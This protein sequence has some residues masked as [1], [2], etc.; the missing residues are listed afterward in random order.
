MATFVQRG[1]LIALGLLIGLTLLEGCLR[2]AALVLPQRLQRAEVGSTSWSPD[3]LVILCVGDSHTYGVGVAPEEAYPAQVERVLRR[4]GFHARVIN[5]GVP[6]RNTEQ[7][8]E[9]LD[10]VIGRYDPRLVLVW[11]G[12]NNQWVPL[13]DAA[14][15]AL[16]LRDRIR[17]F[18]FVRLLLNRYEGVSGDFRTELEIALS[19]VA[20]ETLGA[21]PPAREL[22]AA[23]VTAD[24]TLRDMSAVIE[25]V[26]GAR[27][28]PVLVTYPVTLGPV[29]GL[30]DEAIVTAG[31]THG[32][33][34]VDTR[35]VARRHRTQHG[36][37]LLPDMHPNARLYR[38]IGWEIARVL[39]R[40]HRLDARVAA[41]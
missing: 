6:G 29:L 19:K 11:A 21:Q 28:V 4:R 38:A 41:R 15:P 16:R 22:R 25:V 33:S 39:V 23:Q 13:D 2:L 36:T 7:L 35:P 31:A 1:L 27:A 40:E 37:L 14:M 3:D 32:A 8:L 34:V 30:I 24:M 5:A 26:K 17:L 9:V 20:P 12:A 10:S 18:R